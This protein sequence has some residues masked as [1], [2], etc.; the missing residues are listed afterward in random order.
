MPAAAGAPIQD[1]PVLIE[2]GS[3]LGDFEG[4]TVLGPPST[5]GIATLV[6]RRSR[7]T[8]TTRISSRDA[9]HVHS[10][11]QIR[12]AELPRKQRQSLTF[13]DGT[14]FSFCAGLEKQIDLKLY[15]AQPGRPT[16]VARTRTPM[17]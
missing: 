3:R 10:R 13:D 12:L 5:G 2:E 17:A 4:D 14:E 11:I 7:Y 8:I 16:R 1:R 9:S 15:F 6:C